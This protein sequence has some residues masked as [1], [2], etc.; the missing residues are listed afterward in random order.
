MYSLWKR[1]VKKDASS[2]VTNRIQH[3]KKFDVPQHIAI[4]MDGNGRWAKK[5]AMPRV[6]GHHE[7]MKTVRKITKV[8]NNLGVKTLTVYAFST[9]N[10]KRPKSEVDFLMKLPQEFLGTFL[11]ELISENVRV[12][13]IGD[14]SLIPSHTQN[15]VKRAMEDTKDNDGMI[16]NFALNYGSRGEI[17][18]A[19]NNIIQDA[20]NGIIKENV[21]E[22]MISSYLMTK[23]LSD[24][25][26]LIRT[27]G[28][29]RLSNFMLWQSAYTELWFTEVLWPDFS[30]EHLLQAVE[31]YQ[32]RSRRFGGV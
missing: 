14:L 13:T 7:G 29:I 3:I 18:S 2:D 28:E 30:E 12:E 32:K 17:V 5:R 8:A 22:E 4:I 31:E 27:S 20:K 24:P 9:E 16:L 6:A 25:D 26:L 11:P 23:H 10:W 1:F 21:S 15:A 19:V